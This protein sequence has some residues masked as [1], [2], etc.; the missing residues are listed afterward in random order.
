MDEDDRQFNFGKDM[1]AL[2]TPA[3]I[4][5]IIIA[6]LFMFVTYL[7]GRTW[8][9]ATVDL[10]SVQAAVHNL[11]N[12]KLDIA[13]YDRDC[14]ISRIEMAKKATQED[15]KRVDR[16]LTQILDVLI[17]PGSKEQIRAEL[18]RNR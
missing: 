13:R 17:N 14:E 6:L 4:L 8:D 3:R 12:N 16:R 1:R 18:E 11:Q 9:K 5:A 10:T 7:A 2:V 15:M